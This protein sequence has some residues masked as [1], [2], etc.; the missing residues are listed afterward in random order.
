MFLDAFAGS[1]MRYWHDV[2]HAILQ[3]RVGLCWSNRWLETY[4]DH[5]IGVNLHDLKDLE[6]YHPPSFGDVDFDDVF[7]QLP[8]RYIE[9]VGDFDMAPQKRWW[10]PG[11][12][13]LRIPK[14]ARTGS[15]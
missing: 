6:E 9:G 7:P 3:E 12:L 4:K 13:S 1:N 14:I 10:K 5:L 15:L 11:N 8:R 2:G